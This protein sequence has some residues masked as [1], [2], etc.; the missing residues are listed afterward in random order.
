MRPDKIPAIM[1]ASSQIESPDFLAKGAFGGVG[2]SLTVW[3]LIQRYH[4]CEK[5]MMEA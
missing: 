2:D 5:E 4:L 1:D 3:V